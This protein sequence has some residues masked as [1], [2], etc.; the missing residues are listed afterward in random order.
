MA[1][2]ADETWQPLIRPAFLEVLW[3]KLTALWGQLGFVPQEGQAQSSEAL[4][5][6]VQSREYPL[7]TAWLNLRMIM[8]SMGDI[9]HADSVEQLCFFFVSITGPSMHASLYKACLLFALICKMGSP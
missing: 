9:A 5:H 1:S 4:R 6:Y 3:L 7:G 8:I 2:C